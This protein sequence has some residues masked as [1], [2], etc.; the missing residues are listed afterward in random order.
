MKTYFLCIFYL[1]STAFYAQELD[2]IL[3]ASVKLQ[4]NINE[5][6]VWAQPIL[7][8]NEDLGEYQNTSIDLGVRR[9]LG[10]GWS[11]AFISRT[12][13]IPG[14]E[15]NIQFL[16]ADVAFSREVKKFKVNTR[17][18]YHHALDLYDLENADFIRPKVGAITSTFGK[19]KPLVNVEPWWQLNSIYA[20][21]RIRY[22]LGFKYELSS[23]SELS[24][25]LWR[26][27]F[28]NRLPKIINN[29]WILS[30]SYLL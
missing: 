22:E 1:F 24:A 18:R 10:K 16:W 14:E 28:Q 5:Y 25:I 8:L 15:N 12:W 2:N 19:F 9:K 30:V 13:F 6:S 27:E 21:E 23:R 3:W 26:E 7:R 20:I 4:K 17:V 29:L 11:A